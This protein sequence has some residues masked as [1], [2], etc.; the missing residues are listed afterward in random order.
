MPTEH[1]VCFIVSVFLF[2]MCRRV[3][4]GM[5]SEFSNRILMSN[6]VCYICDLQTKT[7]LLGALS[8]G[9]TYLSWR[10]DSWFVTF[11][12]LED[13]C[14]TRWSI[15]ENEIHSICYRLQVIWCYWVF[16]IQAGH[17]CKLKIVLSLELYLAIPWIYVVFLLKLSRTIVCILFLR[18]D[19]IQ[20]DTW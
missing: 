8:A 3:Y 19:W 9:T 12:V 18:K 6:S 10:Q 1:K 15:K 14:C 17:L 4:V 11:W 20:F 16:D 2:R 13:R 5:P 7:I